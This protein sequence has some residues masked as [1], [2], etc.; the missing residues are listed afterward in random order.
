MVLEKLGNSP[1][2]SLYWVVLST[3]KEML[4]NCSGLCFQ[5]NETVYYE[6][7]V[8]HKECFVILE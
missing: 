4:V 6:Y 5:H 8:F 2:S 1:T 7:Y 3:E